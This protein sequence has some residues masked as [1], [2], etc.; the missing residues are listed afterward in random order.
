MDFQ[1]NESYW[2]EQKLEAERKLRAAEIMLA[3]FA[4]DKAQDLTEGV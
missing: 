2:Y 3:K 1:I 4:L